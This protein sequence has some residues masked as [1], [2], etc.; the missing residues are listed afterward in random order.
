MSTLSNEVTCSRYVPVAGA[1]HSNAAR[2]YTRPSATNHPSA[3]PTCSGP[4]SSSSSSTSSRCLTSATRRTDAANTFARRQLQAQTV[5]RIV[6][7]RF[8]AK[9][10]SKPFV[11]VGGMNDY[12]PCDRRS[13]HAGRDDR[14]AAR[15]R[16]HRWRDSP[17]PCV[18][19]TRPRRVPQGVPRP[20]SKRLRRVRPWVRATV[21]G[22][23]FFD[24]Y[25]GQRGV[26]PNDIELHPV[27]GFAGRCKPT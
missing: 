8:G 21:T 17:G 4:T 22:V 13:A 24:F 7:K 25:H 16:L 15:A 9:P 2:Y 19:A 26:A 5:R 1:T 14:G 27:I 18:D 11:V 20:R 6:E 23:G 3:E 12:V 10:G